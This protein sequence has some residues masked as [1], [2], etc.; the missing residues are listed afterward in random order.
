MKKE[1]K[2]QPEPATMAPIIL[3]CVNLLGFILIIC[4]TFSQEEN[5]DFYAEKMC[6]LVGNCYNCFDDAL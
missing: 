6:D 1:Q 4:I 3:G 2:S 5:I